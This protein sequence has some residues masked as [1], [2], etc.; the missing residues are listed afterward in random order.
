MS[1]TPPT[2][3]YSVILFLDAVSASWHY[4]YFLLAFIFSGWSV[5]RKLF[6]TLTR[7]LL[8]EDTV[9]GSLAHVLEDTSILSSSDLSTF[10]NYFSQDSTAVDVLRSTDSNFSSS[11]ST[12]SIPGP[13]KSPKWLNKS[14]SAGSI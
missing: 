14:C 8:S 9:L 13:R 11:K 4:L 2:R 3:M 6:G 1:L 10:S 5:S 12:I 7:C